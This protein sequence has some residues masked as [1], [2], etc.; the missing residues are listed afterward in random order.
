MSKAGASALTLS[1]GQSGF[2]AR[3]DAWARSRKPRQERGRASLTL[4]RE[5]LARGGVRLFPRQ[6]PT[7]TFSGVP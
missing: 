5:D 7:G 6:P 3:G 1:Y 2:T 4:R